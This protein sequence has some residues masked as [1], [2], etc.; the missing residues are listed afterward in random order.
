LPAPIAIFV[1]KREAHTRRLLDSLQ[2]CPEFSQSAVTIFCEGPKNSDEEESVVRTRRLV[3]SMV[4]DARIVER[5]RNLGCA[6]SIIGGVTEVCDREGRV[7]VVEDDLVFSPHALCYFNDA[8][9]F[10][11]HEERVMHVAG[12]MY[13]VRQAVPEAFLYREVTCW[14]WATWRRAWRHFEP[15]TA[16]SIEW[17]KTN[18]SRS[19]FDIRDSMDFW[20]MLNQQLA[21]AIDAWDIR[22]YASMFRRNGLALHSG[23]ALVANMGLDGSGVHCPPTNNF[24]VVLRQTPLDRSAFPKEITESKAALRAMIDFRYSLRPN[25]VMRAR[26][27]VGRI[28][29]RLGLLAPLPESRA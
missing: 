26:R 21:H 5:D 20:H 3:R 27:S 9:D 23:T 16:K 15:D 25:V 22:W 8:L 10:Y 2:A 19:E 6:N 18:A 1:Y 12:Y 13:P 17:L 28:A 4:P 29:R 14:G 11:E 7:I 24:D